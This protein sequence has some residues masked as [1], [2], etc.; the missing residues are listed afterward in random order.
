MASDP[1]RRPTN[2]LAATIARLAIRRPMKTRRT[3]AVA[4]RPSGRESGMG[5]KLVSEACLVN[6]SEQSALEIPGLR[7]VEELQV[8]PAGAGERERSEEHTSELQSRQYLV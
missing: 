5:C 6:G 7:D 8:I 2:D 3:R 1:E 4:G